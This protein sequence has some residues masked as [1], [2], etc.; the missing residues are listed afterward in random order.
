LAPN[1]THDAAYFSGVRSHLTRINHRTPF[2]KQYRKLFF[3]TH[4]LFV[5]QRLPVSGHRS[6]RSR[7]RLI[8]RMR[9]RSGKLRAFEEFLCTIVVK[10]ILAWLE[11]RDDRMTRGRV[12]FRCMLVWRSIT[13]SD[14]TAFGASAKMQPPLA[15]SQAFDAT[16]SACLGRWVDTIPLG[17]HRL[18]TDFILP[19]SLLI[20]RHPILNA[21][22]FKL[23]DVAGSDPQHADYGAAIPHNLSIEYFPAP[24]MYN[25]NKPPMMLRFL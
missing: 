8:L 14:V 15:Y 7:H 3:R 20:N 5:Q 24:E 6:G 13:A 22:D 9:M 18:L 21:S 17:F 1:C 10:P 2:F 4:P 16:R 11:A 23:R 19:K 12:M 25:S